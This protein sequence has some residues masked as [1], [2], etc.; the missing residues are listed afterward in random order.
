MR[1]IIQKACLALA[2]SLGF[3]GYSHSS[4]LLSSPVK[5]VAPLPEIAEPQRE[6]RAAWVATVAN[7]DWPTKSTLTTDEQKAEAIVILDR[8]VEL[9]MNAVVWQG[10]PAA[11]ALYNSNYE[12][13]SFFLTNEQ[14]TAPDP[15]YDPLEF[16]VDEAH[17]RGLEFHVWFNPYRA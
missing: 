6:F 10:R 3:I 15:Y 4:S 1:P 2:C 5:G 11:D 8:L 16:W 14:G 13:W 12:P 9:N 17:K 7:I